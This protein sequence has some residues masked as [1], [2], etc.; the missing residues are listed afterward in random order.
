MYISMIVY[1]YIC[2]IHIDIYIYNIQYVYSIDGS[3]SG[4]V[5]ILQISLVN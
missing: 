2:D 1:I 4:F 5:D 3:S